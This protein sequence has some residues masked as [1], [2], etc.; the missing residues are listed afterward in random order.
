MNRRRFDLDQFLARLAIVSRRAADV[1]SFVGMTIV[2]L[3][4]LWIVLR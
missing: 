4:A 2:I 3:W 1:V